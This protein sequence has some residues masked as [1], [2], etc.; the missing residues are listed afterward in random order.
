MKIRIRENSIR[1]RLSKSEVDELAEKGELVQYTHFP[2]EHGV[3]FHY[4]LRSHTAH[5]DIIAGH[6]NNGIIIS[7]PQEQLSHWAGT[8]EVGI[9]T[10]L[11]I[12]QEEELRI[13]IEKDF[14]CLTVREHEDDSD[15]F[16]NPNETC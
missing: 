4:G 2:V 12:A 1:F 9:E 13:L 15:A 7:I 8:E 3:S 6:E 10:F 11:P 14:A 5:S 16:A